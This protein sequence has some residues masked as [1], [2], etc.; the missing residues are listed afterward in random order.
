MTT[1][2]EECARQIIAGLARGRKRL[3]VGSGAGA[4]HLISRLFPNSYGVVLHRLLRM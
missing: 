4:L 3:L 2:P 1:S